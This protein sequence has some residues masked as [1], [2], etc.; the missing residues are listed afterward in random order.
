[1]TDQ[2]RELLFVG[3]Y[4]A[5]AALERYVSGDLALRLQ[6]RG[7]RIAVTSRATSRAGRVFGI[8]LKSWS[9]RREYQVACVDV[10]SGPSFFWAEAVCR[11]LQFLRKPYVLTLHGG[12]LPEFGAKYPGR[13]QAL[14]ASAAAV[15]CPSEFLLAKMSSFR[16]QMILLP[17]ALDIGRYAFRERS[18]NLS[19]LVWLRAFHQI[20]NPEM[21]LDVLAELLRQNANCRLT[22]VGPDKGDGSLQACQKKALQLGVTD[23]VR[24]LGAIPKEEVPQLLATQDLF[25]NTTNF[26]NTP[27]SVLE[28]MACGLPVVTTNVGG[29]PFLLTDQETALLVEPGDFK[30]MSDAVQRLLV[31]PCLAKALSHNGRRR[32]E[33]FD[34]A[35]QLPR[36]EHLLEQTFRDGLVSSIQRDG[37]S[38]ASPMT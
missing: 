35:I 36:W 8:L 11:L 22:M 19:E 7:W 26:D 24:F 38:R 20:Y 33:E 14:L 32:V 27:V 30:S 28:A 9:L 15:T 16:Q 4:P 23:R 13:V 3:A 10:F 37:A 17:N 31:S 34:W 5:P 2:P 21:A 6:A 1:M 25:V 18:S 29:I 12:S